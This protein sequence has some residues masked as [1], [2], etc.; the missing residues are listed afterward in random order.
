MLLK[1]DFSS[2]IPIYMQIRN[3]IVLGIS[4]GYLAP[5]ERLPTI[6][7]MADES[8]INMMTVNKAYQLLKQEGYITTDRRNGVFVSSK[9]RKLPGLSDKSKE[10]LRIILSEAYL[11]GMSKQDFLKLCE[12]LFEETERK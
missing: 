3:Q 1:L 7:S 10:T 2:D 9:T 11:N 4:K 8:G 12:N 6:R 5:G